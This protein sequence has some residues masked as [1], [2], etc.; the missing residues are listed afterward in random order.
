MGVDELDAQRE[1]DTMNKRLFPAISFSLVLLTSCAKQQGQPQV[2]PPTNNAPSAPQEV[3]DDANPS[4]QIESRQEHFFGDWAKARIWNL[5]GRK[6]KELTS[7]LLV[8]TDGK[9]DKNN[10]IICRWEDTSKPMQG[11]LVLLVEYGRPF[12]VKCKRL[13]LLSLSFLSGGPKT[14][15]NM[16]SSALVPSDMSSS[17]PVL[18]EVGC[19][20]STAS[21]A[22]SILGKEVLYAEVSGSTKEGWR[23]LLLGGGDVEDRLVES[24]KNGGV[25]LAVIV[26]WKQ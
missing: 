2:A 17:A 16:S 19:T 8:Y 22:R 24:S 10:K 26:E 5:R 11:Q 9:A 20:F 25:S 6:V 14:T 3:Q 7:R 12:G 18:S 15:T 21:D 13:P 1:G 4:L 23:S